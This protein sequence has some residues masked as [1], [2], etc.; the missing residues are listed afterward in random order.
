MGRDFTLLLQMVVETIDRYGLKRLHLAKHRKDVDRFYTQLW[1]AEYRSEVAE[2]YQ[3]R[4]TKNKDKLFTF[5]DH[6]GVPWNNNNG[7]NAIKRFVALRKVLGTAFSED[8]IKDYL[9][10]LSISQT[11]RY[12]NRSFWKF[13][14]SGETDITTFTTSRR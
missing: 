9:V 8:G 1:R 6:D 2:Y 12:R 10:L 13:L 3:K 14:L 7:E 11:L 4:L 5:L